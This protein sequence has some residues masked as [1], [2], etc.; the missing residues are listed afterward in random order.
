MSIFEEHA[1]I[2]IKGKREVY[3]GH[4]INLSITECG[5]RNA[6]GSHSKMGSIVGGALVKDSAINDK[7]IVRG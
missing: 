2:I 4:K 1:G 7:R 3:Y 5:F 6:S